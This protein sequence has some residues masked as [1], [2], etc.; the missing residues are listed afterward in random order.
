MQRP[1]KPVI[2]ISYSHD[3]AEVASRIAVALSDA[4]M[5]PWIDSV[6]IKPGDSFLEM[7]NKGLGTASYL[8]AL[9]SRSSQYSR[10][11]SRE[12]LAAL[13]SKDTV[14]IPV[15]L[16]DSDVPP[17][18][19]DIVHIDMGR[20]GTIENGVS[21]LTNFFVR[22]SRGR[23]PQVQAFQQRREDQQQQQQQQQ[24]QDQQ[25][26]QWR[27]RHY[28][29]S[30]AAPRQIRLVAVRCIDSATLRSYCFDCGRDFDSLEGLSLT[31]KL[32]WLLNRLKA[33]QI[34]DQFVGWLENEKEQCV[35]AQ[36]L[37]LSD[38]PGWVWGLDRP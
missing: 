29:L 30:G 33:E 18:L 14:V 32:V 20:K 37:A 10:W 34:L 38:S 27:V 1:V 26:D 12:W 36:I 22:E 28:M 2:F 23:Q 5:K 15:L 6:E 17:L 21:E 16:D 9:L 7:M 19:R 8:V 24:Q 25:Q 4:G 11:M 13:A 35:R 31:D 3:D